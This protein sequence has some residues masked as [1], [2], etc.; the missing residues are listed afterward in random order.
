MGNKI[1][2]D[3]VTPERLIVSEE[4]DE[5]IAP[6]TLGDF[7][8]LPDHAPFFST[9]RIGELTY[10]KGG[11]MSFVAVSWGFAQVYQ[12]RVIV[13]AELAEKPEEIDMIKVSEAIARA[14]EKLLSAGDNLQLLD[15]A[16]TSLEK[17]LNRKQIAEKLK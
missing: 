13:L 16:R 14:E 4:V 3:I 12:N 11:K 2:L 7:G 1:H 10:R 8:V 17:A 5:I 9:L 6:G 15:E